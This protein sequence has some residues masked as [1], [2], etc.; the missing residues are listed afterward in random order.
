MKVVTLILAVT[1][2]MLIWTSTNAEDN[3]PQPPKGVDA[4]GTAMTELQKNRIDILKE[5]ADM[6]LKLSQAARLELEVALEDRITL[7]KAESQA[8]DSEPERIVIYNRTLEALTEYE[9]LA[10]S[11]KEAARGSELAVLRIK[12][13]RLE[14]EILL[15]EAKEKQKE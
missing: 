13:R 12:A 14:V 4:S 1:T 7:L 15:A 8:A 2:L 10:R 5:V 3:V 9:Q 11:Q 6:S